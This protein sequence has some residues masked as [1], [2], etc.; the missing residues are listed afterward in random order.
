VSV[1]PRTNALGRLPA[2]TTGTGS[3]ASATRTWVVRT[4][5][6][7]YTSRPSSLPTSVLGPLVASADRQLSGELSWLVV[8]ISAG[9]PACPTAWTSSAIAGPDSPSTAVAPAP[10]AAPDVVPGWV[11]VIETRRQPPGAAQPGVAPR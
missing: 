1:C 8:M 10:S 7:A 4:L 3:A 6:G 2:A 9:G 5:R 11:R